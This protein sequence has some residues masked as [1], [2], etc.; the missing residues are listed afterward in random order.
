LDFPQR[1]ARGAIIALASD[2]RTLPTEADQKSPPF[3]LAA[4]GSWE[5]APQKKSPAEWA[6]DSEVQENGLA[7]YSAAITVGVGSSY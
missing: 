1:K 3:S 4:A 7:P 5:A 2:P 6:G